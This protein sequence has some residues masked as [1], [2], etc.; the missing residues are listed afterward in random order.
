MVDR[1]LDGHGGT[2][3]HD[4]R[5]DRSVDGNNSMADLEGRRGEGIV[6]LKALMR[7]VG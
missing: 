3:V 5:A 1:M 2:Y 4:S 7:V 6:T